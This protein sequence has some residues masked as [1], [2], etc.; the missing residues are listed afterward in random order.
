M[1]QSKKEQAVVSRGD[2]GRVLYIHLKIIFGF[3]C[4]GKIQTY[5]VAQENEPPGN[6]S[7]LQHCQ[8]MVNVISSLSP[9]ILPDYFTYKYFMMYLQDKLL[10]F[11]FYTNHTTIIISE[12]NLFMIS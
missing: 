9:P 3:L 12:Q 4:Y 7:L 1:G 10:F 8:L 2:E 5:K 6:C 11:S